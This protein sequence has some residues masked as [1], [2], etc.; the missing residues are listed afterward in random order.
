M[1][2]RSG[3]RAS[4]RQVTVMLQIPSWPLTQYSSPM[5]SPS[6]M[7]VDPSQPFLSSVSCG[8]PLRFTRHHLSRSLPPP[9]K[10]L[11]RLHKTTEMQTP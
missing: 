9:G 2:L 11:L 1:P 10:E 8:C 5:L 6:G 4:R 3:L 7:N